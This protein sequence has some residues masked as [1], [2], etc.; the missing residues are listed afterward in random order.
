MDPH[1]I[2]LRPRVSE[3][4]MAHVEARNQYSFEV[5]R[6]ANKIEIARAVSALFDVKVVDVQTMSQ[7]GKARRLGWVRGRTPAWKKAIVKLAEGERIDLF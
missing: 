4:G 3:K 5:A 7:K 6:G 1:R 2:I